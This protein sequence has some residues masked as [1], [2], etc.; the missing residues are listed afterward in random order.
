MADSTFVKRVKPHQA[1]RIASRL[2]QLDIELTE[3]CNNDCI[4]C[5]I[6]LPANDA[7]A[8]AREM[9]TAQVK[10]I[11]HQAADLGCLRVRFTGGEPLLRPDFEELYLC[12]RRLG[13][14]VLL[15]TNARLITP[16]L[17]DLF[18]RIPPK[19]EIEI[20]VYG[21]RAESYEAVTRAPG[22]FAQF[23]R[24]V[25]LL[26]ERNAPFIVKQSLLPP[27]AHEIDEF[28][29]WAKTI[30]WMN[31]RPSY[32]MNF[33]L[34]NRRDDAAKNRAVA[35]MRLSPDETI[36]I[37]ARDA[38][39]YRASMAEFRAKKFMGVPGNKLFNCGACSGRSGCLDAYGR[40]QPCMG[41]RV[42]ALTV[43]LLNSNDEGEKGRGGE[44]EQGSRGAE[45]SRRSNHPTNK[46]A[47]ALA[48][49]PHLRELRATN[50]EYLRRCAQC[51]LK[52]L[53]EQCPAKSWAESGTLDTPVEYLCEVAHAQ[54]R[55]LGWLGENEYGWEK[56][57]QEDRKNTESS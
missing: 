16:H 14:K 44:R 46:L 25:N 37:L 27:N 28:E 57:L 7:N 18:A 55:Y 21:L 40:L 12:A 6:N 42:P 23:W 17:A 30:P 20:T 5:C 1:P 24:G 33:D 53:C 26:L 47:N 39:K 51:F 36:A 35:A 48:N 2:G 15:F 29:A 31:K 13:I 41:I 22:S 9:T 4:H 52:G 32:A 49:F 54:A 56:L 11:L 3:R 43:D 19:V 8:R 45:E 38:D 50:P 10:D 34:R